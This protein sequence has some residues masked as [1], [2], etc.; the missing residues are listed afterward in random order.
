M[1]S[2]DIKTANMHCGSCKMLVEMSVT[3]LPGIEK[4]EVDLAAETTHVE[5]DPAQVSVDDIVS[6]IR[7]AG[8]GAEVVA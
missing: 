1:E 8:Y 6:A 7:T 2:V 5:Y 3:E 4:A